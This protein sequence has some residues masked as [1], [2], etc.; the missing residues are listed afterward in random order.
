M[1][2][3][4]AL[5]SGLQGTTDAVQMVQS[6]RHAVQN[7]DGAEPVIQRL[8][9]SAMR[10]PARPDSSQMGWVLHALQNAFFE[11]LHASSFEEGLVATVGRGG[12]TDTNGAIA[13]ALLGARHGAADM[14]TAWMRAVRSCRPERGRARQARPPSYWPIDALAVSEQ[15]A[16]ERRKQTDLATAP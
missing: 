7:L 13:G 15:L 3:V 16:R 14:P 12:D 1:A 8:D 2:F 10:P 6:A 5:C 4:A 11:L 9:D